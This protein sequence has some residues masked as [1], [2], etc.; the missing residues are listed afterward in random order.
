[1][2]VYRLNSPIAESTAL[3]RMRSL[4]SSVGLACCSGR[5][6][7]RSARMAGRSVRIARP[8]VQMA[9]CSVRVTRRPM[10]VTR[11]S[12]RVAAADLNGDGRPDLAITNS[13][14]VSI[15]LNACLP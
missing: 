12:V 15:L 6:P 1:M 3:K 9:G 5:L 14:T 11:R 8:S 10:R 7:G 2:M 13:P 4:G